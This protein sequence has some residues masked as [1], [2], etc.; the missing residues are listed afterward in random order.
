MTNFERIKKMNVE[1][2]A[3]FIDVVTE[4][5]TEHHEKGC[6]KCPICKV[7]GFGFCDN[8]I[9]IKFLESEVKE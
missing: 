5:C 6:A 7:N 4:I 1:E 3:D 2:L 9:I 8:K